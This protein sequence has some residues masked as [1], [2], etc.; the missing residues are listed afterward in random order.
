MHIC[1]VN[2]FLKHIIG[3]LYIFMIYCDSIKD[4]LINLQKQIYT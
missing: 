4:Y 1:D 3:R 2:V